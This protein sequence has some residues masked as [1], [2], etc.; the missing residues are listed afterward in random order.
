MQN[1]QK[2]TINKINGRSGMLNFMP[3]YFKSF[4]LGYT[5]ILPTPHDVVIAQILSDHILEHLHLILALIPTD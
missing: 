2:K 1:V 5:N 4:R 3:I